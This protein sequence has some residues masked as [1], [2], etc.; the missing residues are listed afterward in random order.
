MVCFLACFITSKRPKHHNSDKE[1]PPKD[2]DLKASE[3]LQ[4][5][6]PT[7]QE[8]AGQLIK[9]TRESK[10]EVE[11]QVNCSAKK[12]VTFDLNAKA[13]EEAPSAK[14]V[15]CDLV[16]S[17][18]EKETGNEEEKPK[19]TEPILDTTALSKGGFFTP[20]NRY[21]DCRKSTD[22]YDGVGL[23]ESDLEEDDDHEAD[24]KGVVLQE[25][26]SESLF[27][28]SIDSRK[29]VFDPENGEK[30]VSSPM[31]MPSFCEEKVKTIGSC[32]NAGKRSQAG[33]SVLK[34]IE[35][36]SQ[37]KEDVKEDR[38]IS[39]LVKHQEKENIS[40]KPRFKLEYHSSKSKF[41]EIKA[42]EQEIGVDTSLSSWLIGS[43]MALKSN[44]GCGHSAVDSEKENASSSLEDNRV[45]GESA[46]F[47]AAYSSSRGARSQSPDT[48]PTIGTVGSYWIH[49]GQDMDSDTSPSFGGMP[50][51]EREKVVFMS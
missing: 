40:S 12:R 24:D 1:T 17:K 16:E 46:K 11:E 37:R 28:L 2:Q 4:L 6:E 48:T 38:P 20:N 18:E 14:E 31:P 10:E 9:L 49:T 13:Y 25:E 36:L 45:L 41:S 7:K 34:P 42:A 44:G 23:E 51:T 43:E 21:Q 47:S 5:I 8:N 15:S 35:N 27:S 32:Q 39:P 29:Q 30:E 3:A 22:D 19:E 26:S 50:L 33:H